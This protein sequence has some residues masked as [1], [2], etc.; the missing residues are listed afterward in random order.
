LNWIVCGRADTLGRMNDQASIATHVGGLVRPM[1]PRAQ[2]EVV[3]VWEPP[4]QKLS[5]IESLR[6]GAF[7]VVYLAA[8]YVGVTFMEWAWMRIFG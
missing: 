5:L 7:M 4:P 2:I 1:P 6:A 8:G 3:R